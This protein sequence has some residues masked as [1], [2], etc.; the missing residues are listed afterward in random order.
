MCLGESFVNGN[1][2]IGFHFL[3]LIKGILVVTV[4]YFHSICSF[5]DLFEI[6]LPTGSYVFLNLQNVRQ[7]SFYNHSDSQVCINGGE[8]FLR[9]KD[10]CYSTITHFHHFLQPIE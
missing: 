9:I 10:F 3:Y 7:C 2:L 1:F 8:K 5:L 4:N 6:L